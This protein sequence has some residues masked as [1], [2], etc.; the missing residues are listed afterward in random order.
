MARFRLPPIVLPP[1]IRVAGLALALAGCAAV[2]PDFQPP[3]APDLSTYGDAASARARLTPEARTAG[4]WWL[5]LGSAELD[6][7]I[8]QALKDSPTLDEADALL[9]RDQAMVDA[10]RGGRRPQGDLA[11]GAQRQRFNTRT[12]PFRNIPSPTFNV[13]S[14]GATVAYDLDPFG[15]GRRRVERAQAQAEAQ[16]HRADAA[17]LALTGEIALQAVQIAALRA[18]I[19]AL[20]ATLDEDR[21]INRMIAE[22]IRAGGEA[23]GARAHGEAQLAEDEADLAPLRRDLDAARHRLARLAGHAP[24]NLT[25][26]DF[27]LSG[28]VLPAQVPVSLPS[29]LVRQRPDILAAEAELHAATAGIGVATAA[30]Y[31]DLRLTAGLTQSARHPEDLFGFS[32]SGWNIGAGLAAPL[33]RGGALKAERRAAEADARAAMARY[34]QT[35]LIAFTQVAD[36]LGALDHDEA[37]LTARLRAEAARAETLRLART[38][39]TLGGGTFRAVIEAQRDLG[40]A[41]RDRIR[42]E[43]ERHKDII[44]LF[45]ATAAD[46]RTTETARR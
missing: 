17:Y 35:V 36:A 33:L 8:R 10:A 32:A 45:A 25:G 16:A 42:A 27:D 7:L 20:Q 46:W 9:A 22:A 39:Q 23:S 12:F 29:A 13:Y 5:A 4:A 6:R 44:R 19:A 14:V 41:R 38:A 1:P 34:Q 37:A 3:A 18:E 28:F 11:A 43:A 30:L 40:Q 24:G 21:Q 15:A 26:A 2:G 31:P